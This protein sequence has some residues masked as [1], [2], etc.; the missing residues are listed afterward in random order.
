MNGRAI[1]L[2]RELLPASAAARPIDY[3]FP[4]RLEEIAVLEAAICANPQDAH[5]PYLLGNL[6]YDRR[7]HEEAVRCWQQSVKI[8]ATLSIAWRNLGIGYFNVLKK[9]EKARAAYDK[10]FRADPTARVLYERDQLWKRLAASPKKR[11]RQ[12]QQYTEL[13]SQ[14][15]DLGVE[16][17]ALLNQTGHYAER[18]RYC[19]V[20]T[21]SPGRAA[22]GSPCGSTFAAGSRS[23]ERRFLA[24][25]RRRPRTNSATGSI[26]RVIW[27]KRSTCSPT[28]ATS[29]TGSVVPNRPLATRQK[30]QHWQAAAT[31]KGDFQEMRTRQFSEKTYDSALAWRR[32]GRAAKAD[33]LLRKLLAYARKLEKTPATI[34]YFATS[35]PTMLLFDDDLNERQRTN[36][37]FLQAQG[38][39]G[40][41]REGQGPAA[42]EEGARPRPQPR[43]G[44]GP[45]GR[46]VAI[47]LTPPTVQP[48]SPGESNYHL[49][50][51]STISIVAALGGLLFGYDWVVIGGAKPFF[52]P[53]FGIQKESF[54]SGWANSCACWAACS[55]QSAAAF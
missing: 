26:R 5:A 27:A 41:G 32:L 48:S 35:L 13:V 43:L 11:L 29:T 34:D 54:S 3:C 37:M 9:P 44:G 1:W 52:E 24:A 45:H 19:A 4:A 30:Q 51:I 39:L 17:A 18:S 55:D 15:D 53:Y 42:V 40:L 46:T 31:F 2:C 38:R 50:Y 10:A 33:A 25:T 7:R 28:R 16:Y 23:A 14:R 22:K 21:S 6:L 36:A 47:V 8:D 20:G 12:L 49:G